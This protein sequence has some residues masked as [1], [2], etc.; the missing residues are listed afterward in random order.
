MRTL[1]VV[2][3]LVGLSV[4]PG[5]AAKYFYPNASDFQC[6]LNGAHTEGHNVYVFHKNRRLQKRALKILASQKPNKHYP[7]GTILQLF[8]FEATVKVGKR[9]NPEADGW[10]FC[11][12][13]PTKDGTT[14]L[15]CGKSEI[16]NAL[17]HVSC[18]GCHGAAAKFDFVCDNPEHACGSLG[19]S[20][21]IIETLQHGDPRCAQQP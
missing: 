19:V 7:I 13:T 14:N 2:V 17:N 1:A 20:Q 5:H 3:A 10:M 6:L 11:T 16:V 12:F 9:F 15:H 8:P 21:T 4:S 18:Q